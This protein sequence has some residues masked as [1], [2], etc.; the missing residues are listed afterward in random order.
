MS[1]KKAEEIKA[2]LTERIQRK[3]S[4]DADCDIEGFDYIAS[5]HIDSMNIMMF[6]IDLEAKFDVEFGDDEIVADSFR[7]IAGLTRMIE[8][9]INE[10]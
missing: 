5:R 10:Q 8:E 9:K 1:S 4:F 7:T 6:V 2:F 3:K